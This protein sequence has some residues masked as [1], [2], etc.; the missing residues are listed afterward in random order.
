[1]DAMYWVLDLQRTSRVLWLPRAISLDRSV[2]RCSSF[3]VEFCADMKED[4]AASIRCYTHSQDLCG[5]AGTSCICT[6]AFSSFPLV[7]CQTH[8]HVGS[9]L[10]HQLRKPALYWVSTEDARRPR[11]RK[12]GELGIMLYHGRSAV[13]SLCMPTPA[14]R[15][16]GILF[17]RWM[18]TTDRLDD[19][20]FL[21]KV[22]RASPTRSSHGA[23]HQL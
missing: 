23:A 9:A 1:M 3:Q 14:R 10:C 8:A 13:R 2:S 5:E 21:R 18:R 12:R 6:G 16:D 7:E 20:S 15:R 4:L 19:W 11:T 17:K 22:S